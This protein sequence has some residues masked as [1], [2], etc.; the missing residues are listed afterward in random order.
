VAGFEVSTEG[1]ADD[2]ALEHW[3]E[4]CAAF[5]ATLPRKPLAQDRV[6]S[7]AMKRGA[8]KAP[9]KRRV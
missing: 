9:A 5:V 6:G 3:V 8:K 2:T 1:L 7:K 4:L